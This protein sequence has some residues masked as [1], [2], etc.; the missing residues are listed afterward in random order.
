MDWLHRMWETLVSGT[1]TTVIIMFFWIRQLEKR[2]ELLEGKNQDLKRDL[3]DVQEIRN[4]LW[5]VHAGVSR[6]EDEL[7]EVRDGLEELRELW[8]R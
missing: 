2:V 1:P 3:K 7:K 8:E 5:H 6:V 4:E